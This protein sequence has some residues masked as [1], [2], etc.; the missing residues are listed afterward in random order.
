[1]K[2]IYEFDPYEDREDL[3]VF[4][5]AS[6]NHVKIHDIADYLRR[7]TKYDLRDMLP[8]EEIVEAIYNIINEE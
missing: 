6:S 3:E 7:L 2:I 5:A 1:M 8:K 4:Q